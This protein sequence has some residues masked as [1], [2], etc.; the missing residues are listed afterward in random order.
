M[1]GQQALHSTKARGSWWSL[2]ACDGLSGTAAPPWTSYLEGAL[3]RQGALVGLLIGCPREQ[4]LLDLRPT[5]DVHVLSSSH[6]RLGPFPE[7]A[8][9]FLLVLL[10][11]QLTL[12]QVLSACTNHNQRLTNPAPRCWK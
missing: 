11:F 6:P 7:V 10:G 12:P 5:A 3:E 9:S 8:L 4:E 2:Q 1:H